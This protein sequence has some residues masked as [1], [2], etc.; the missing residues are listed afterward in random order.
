MLTVDIPDSLQN[1]LQHFA[2]LAS[3]TIEEAI[4]EILEERIDH[5]SAYDETQYLMKS[6]ANKQRLDNAISDI[7]QGRYEEKALV[8]D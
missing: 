3:Q 8:D 4:L 2:V 1:K 6:K 7:K 5:Q